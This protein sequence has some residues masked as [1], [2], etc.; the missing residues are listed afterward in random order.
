MNR[1]TRFQDDKA[2]FF[3]VLLG[4]GLELFQDLKGSIMNLSQILGGVELL[5]H[6][7]SGLGDDE[8][9]GGFKGLED[10]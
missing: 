1:L 4:F 8:G 6:D 2:V 7:P 3:G 10:P 9:F 5:V